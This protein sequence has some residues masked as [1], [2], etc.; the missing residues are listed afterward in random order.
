MAPV[1]DQ[2]QRPAALGD[3]SPADTATMELRL[4]RWNDRTVWA[5]TALAV[6]SGFGQFGV[7]AA[8]GSVAKSFGHISQGSS[9]ADQAGLS[10]TELG[11]GLAII[12]LA[13]LGGLP[14]SG[15][16]DRF[17]R[18]RVLLGTVTLGLALTAL[19]TVSPGYWWFVVIFALGRP[20]LSATNAVSQV[21]AAEQTG[22]RDRAKAVA[23]VA[24]GYGVGAGITA[25]LHSLFRHTLGFRGLLALCLVP[26]VL[27]QLVRTKVPEPDRYAIAAASP[28]H[29]LP[30]FGVAALHGRHARRL[31][32][33]VAITFMISV[34]TGPAN[35]FVFLFAQSFVHLSGRIT[36][37]MVV[38]AGVSGLA[39]LLAGR[40]LADRVGRR[41]TAALG[42]AAIAAFGV[43]TYTGSAAALVVGYVAG[44]LS[45]A[46]LAPALGA[47][48][49]ELF[50][51]SVRASVAGWV[52]AAGVLGAVAGLLAFGAVA[53]VG[54][55]FGLSAAVLFLPSAL[56][57]AL[58]FALPESKGLEPEQLEAAGFARVGSPRRS[59]PAGA[60]SP[61]E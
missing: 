55:R 8:L 27:V 36:A 34:I 47:L 11:I 38:G 4:R 57:G 59:R 16:A 17:G 18:R 43:L 54:N 60:P 5:V 50:P 52:V 32:L 33:V 44:V 41:P 49:N 29:A 26:L 2:Q 15:L 46:L 6:A 10:G 58:F 53:D 19:T 22:S 23:L 9:I 24:A 40:Y 35:T 42:M 39:G 7:V 25:I 21:T 56:A 3:R 14:L 12:R 28:E 51:T 61:T 13:S 31:W 1:D 37:L 45:G 30:V 48:V 20:L